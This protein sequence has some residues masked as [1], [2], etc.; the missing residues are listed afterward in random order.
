MSVQMLS[1]PAD[2]VD[3]IEARHRYP[4][5]TDEID[6]ALRELVDEILVPGGMKSNSQVMHITGDDGDKLCDG[7]GFDG[8][9]KSIECYPPGFRDFCRECAARYRLRHGGVAD[10]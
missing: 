2:S 3:D 1:V 8:I 4:E 7:R 6:A 9:T 5:V 10:A